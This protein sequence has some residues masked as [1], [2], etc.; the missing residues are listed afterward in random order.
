MVNLDNIDFKLESIFTG[1]FLTTI[2]SIM[3]IMNGNEAIIYYGE[4][5]LSQWNSNIHTIFMPF[6]CYGF[7]LAVP[8]I[9]QLN[10]R[11]ANVLQECVFLFYT[12]HYLT[13]SFYITIPFMCIY[14][15]VLYFA[16]HFYQ[17]NIKN[18]VIGLT[19][20]TV[21]LVIQEVIGHQ[22][23]GDQPS[24]ADGVLNAI[25]YANYYAVK[26]LLPM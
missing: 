10:N 25:L 3:G 4:V 9:M 7:L 14:Y 20:S 8:A 1:Y 15:P 12:A 24:R 2:L 26:N 6:T 18:I 23:G 19:I 22:F 17:N 21:S 16:K 13:I 11:K 5:H